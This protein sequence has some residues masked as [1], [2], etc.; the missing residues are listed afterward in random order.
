MTV[1]DMLLSERY[2][3]K[4]GYA[5]YQL[6]GPQVEARNLFLEEIHKKNRYVHIT[7]CPYCGNQNFIKISEVNKRN[8]P[9]DIVICDSC[10]G[11]F[12]STILD[13]EVTRYYYEKISHIL[14]GK[15]ISQSELEERLEKRIQLFAYPRYWFFSH[16]IELNPNSDLIAELG[17]NDGAN[18]VPWK[19]NGFCVVGIDLDSRMVEFGK[20]KGLNL[21]KGDVLNYEFKGKRP[22]LIILSHVLDHM[23]DV[24]AVFNRIAKILE[25]N[26]YVFIETPNI[27]THGL[28]NPLRYFDV[29]FNYCFDLNSLSRVLKK[30]S[31]NILYADEYT[32]LL[33]TSGRDGS[34]PEDKPIPF[35]L[36]K[37]KASLFK[38]FI[39]IMNFHDKKLYDLLKEGERGSI[40]IRLFSKLQTLYLDSLYK[41][42]T[43]GKR[44]SDV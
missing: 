8:L 18:L 34:I 19:E 26:G 12:K 4:E 37:F 22:K 10:D 14:V 17:C 39:D 38:R 32:R 3:L 36:D 20:K 27:R 23:A 25:P 5:P 35:S 7:A 15:S 21:I 16:F 1:K 41:A 42:I 13:P 30:H 28:V 44:G 31:F 6:S 29:E 40:K 9:S 43:N 24:N 2:R 11:C 33:C